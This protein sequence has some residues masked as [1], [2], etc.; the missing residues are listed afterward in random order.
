MCTVFNE[1]W[2]ALMKYMPMIGAFADTATTTNGTMD[3]IV[4]WVAGIGGG[5]V[6]VFLII[7]LAKDAIGIAKGSGDSSIMKV[8]GKALF[9]ILIIG[10]IFLAMNYSSLGGTAGD[11]ANKGID[12]VDKEV[13]SALGS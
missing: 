4:K 6:A 8:I 2:I 13:N 11:I 12:V 1:L 10:L 9:L 3:G 5:I 7:S